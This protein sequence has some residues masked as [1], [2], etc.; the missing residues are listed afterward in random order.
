MPPRQAPKSAPTMLS[1]MDEL[2]GLKTLAKMAE[3]NATS[4]L[5]V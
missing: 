5:A 4:A 3:L 1:P 2:K